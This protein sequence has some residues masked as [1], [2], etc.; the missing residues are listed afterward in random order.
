MSII[1]RVLDEFD[2]SANIVEIT[3]IKN[4]KFM[5]NEPGIEI[6]KAFKD[7]IDIGFKIYKSKSTIR[8]QELSFDRPNT[9]VTFGYY[10]CVY[11]RKD[12][13]VDI[14]KYKPTIRELGLVGFMLNQYGGKIR[15]NRVLLCND[16]IEYIRDLIE[17]MIDSEETRNKFISDIAKSSYSQDNF[18]YLYY[19]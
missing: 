16:C 11:N 5:L 19:K 3:G 13:V 18:Y 8:V 7:E 14:I 9:I 6:R 15:D 12:D 10:R 2:D 4:F 17:P 1:N